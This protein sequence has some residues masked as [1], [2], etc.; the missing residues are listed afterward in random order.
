M[1]AG[2]DM[3][4]EDMVAADLVVVASCN[5][6]SCVSN[7]STLRIWLH[8]MTRIFF[9]AIWRHVHVM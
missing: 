6:F 8:F 9:L 2:A 4:A 5:S 3:V 7:L 1:E